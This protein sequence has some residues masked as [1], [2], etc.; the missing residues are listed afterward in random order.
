MSI[1]HANRP[2]YAHYASGW[3]WPPYS[4]AYIKKLLLFF[5][6]IA[7]S[8]PSS[9][10]DEVIDKDPTLARPLFE[11]G[12]LVNVEPERALDRETA[13]LLTSALVEA[14]AYLFD[15]YE[16]EMMWGATRGRCSFHMGDPR[17][18]QG[19]ELIE[20]LV[21]HQAAPGNMPSSG[22]FDTSPNVQHVILYFYG[23]AMHRS[24]NNPVR[25]SFAVDPIYFQRP[26][27][28]LS[29]LPAT[30]HLH[31]AREGVFGIETEDLEITLDLEST[32]LDDILEFKE[33][34]GP[35]IRTYMKALR[36]YASTLAASENPGAVREETSPRDS[37]LQLVPEG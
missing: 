18:P 17:S 37:R 26:R 19:L 1:E 30:R 4:D 12:L 8:V 16:K 22:R 7:I 33:Q 21:R 32:P 25:S 23:Q 27:S 34:H 20:L 29:L 36:E 13:E 5:D 15:Y 14:F 6:G 9:A 35:H 10:V 3:I 11:R 31:E 28:V 2:R 24:F